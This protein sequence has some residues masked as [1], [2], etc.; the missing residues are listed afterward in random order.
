MISDSLAISRRA[1]TSSCSSALARAACAN[2]SCISETACLIRRTRKRPGSQ[3]RANCRIAALGF[4]RPSDPSV[5]FPSRIHRD[6]VCFVVPIIRENSAGR[7]RMLIR[8]AGLN[9]KSDCGSFLSVNSV[10]SVISSPSNGHCF[11]LP[12]NPSSYLAFPCGANYPH[13]GTPG[14]TQAGSGLRVMRVIAGL[15]QLLYIFLSLTFFTRCRGITR[16]H[17]HHP[18]LMTLHLLIFAWPSVPD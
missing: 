14:R 5:N 1:S 2:V 6:T 18:H 13:Q 3:V 8:S 10:S 15:F 4:N 9:G 7:T 11:Q 16:N 12:I 17:P